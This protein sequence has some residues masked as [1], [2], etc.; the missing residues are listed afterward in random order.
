MEA[1]VEIFARRYGPWA[2]IVGGSEGIGAS[3]ARKLAARGVNLVL[4]ARKA[5]PLAALASELRETGKAEVR[6]LSVDVTADD[7]LE[8]IRKVTDDIDVGLLIYNAGSVKPQ[9]FFDA[10]LEV[11]LQTM[12]L[13]PIGQ[14]VLAHHFGQSMRTRGR[15]GIILVGSMSGCAGGGGV[16]AYSASKAFT[17]RFAE[18]LWAELRPDN[19][20]VLALVVGGTRTP[21]MERS[22][23]S[24]DHPEHIAAEP[25]L[26]ADVGLEN[27]GN[28]PVQVPPYLADTFKLLNSLP[29]GEAALIMTQGAKA[30]QQE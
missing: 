21:F 1:G 29:R 30:L 27:I 28:G 6:M 7:M 8:R 9:S 11:A 15:G 5:A 22:G 10:P 25:D 18:A 3:F 14:V 19:V 16:A 4:L 26:V 12:K 20:D 17:Q 13:N 24:T 23:L 2:V